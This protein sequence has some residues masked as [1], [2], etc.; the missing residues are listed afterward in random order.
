LSS[1]VLNGFCAEKSS[2]SNMNFN[3]M[4]GRWEALKR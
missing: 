1:F 2:A 4:R 3:S